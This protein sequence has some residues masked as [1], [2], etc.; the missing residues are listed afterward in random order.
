MLYQ[1][2]YTLLVGPKNDIKLVRLGL[3]INGFNLVSCLERFF[4][5]QLKIINRGV[6]F[7]T[8]HPV[9]IL[10]RDPKSETL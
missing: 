1:I 6:A 10:L 7:S 4:L 3:E 9:W 8:G 2:Y 5:N